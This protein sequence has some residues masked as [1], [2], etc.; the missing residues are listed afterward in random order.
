M[1][2]AGLTANPLK[3]KL[4]YD[5]VDNLEYTVGRG[6]VKPQERNV[7]AILD[8]PRPVNKRQVKSLLGLAG[9]YRRFVANF[10]TLAAPLTDLTKARGPVMVRWTE[11]EETA[12]AQL[13]EALTTRP[14]LI[15]PDFRKPM[16]E[17]TDA[18]DTGVGAVLA[19]EQGGEEHPIIYI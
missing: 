15:T 18:C 5:E 13:K 9:Y 3:C 17:Q 7:H 16:T 14:V 8:W 1:K 12:F 19:Q 6:N 2:A 10:A 11:T 4:A